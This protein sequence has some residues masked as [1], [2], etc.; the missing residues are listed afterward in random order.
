MSRKD[1]R[2]AF[3]P[4]ESVFTAGYLSMDNYKFT[5][6]NSDLID[7]DRASFS[8]SVDVLD[9]LYPIWRSVITQLNEFE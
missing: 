8:L 6:D 9:A 1:N 7:A 5:V 2:V 4:L 3:I